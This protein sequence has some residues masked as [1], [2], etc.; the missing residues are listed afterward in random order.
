MTTIREAVAEKIANIG[1]RTREQVIEHFAKI[2]AD[3]Q[4]AILVKGLT[5]LDTAEASLE[6]VDKPDQLSYNQDG[7]IASQAYSLNRINEI[8]KA[9]EKIE[10]IT[11]AITLADEQGNFSA[12]Q[13]IVN[14]EGQQKPSNPEG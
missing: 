9:K 1:P 14:S 3:R 11:S 6:K 7:T 8:K 2:E 5:A 4:A 12:L 13:K 10:K